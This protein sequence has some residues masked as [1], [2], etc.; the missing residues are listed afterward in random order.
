MSTASEHLLK[1]AAL[2]EF[3]TALKYK[4]SYE[5]LTQGMLGLLREFLYY[6]D[7]NGVEV[8][9]KET[10]Y[11]IVSRAQD[12]MLA[13]LGADGSLQENSRQGLDRTR[14]LVL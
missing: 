4:T 1:L 8:P 11:R 6:C 7:K 2:N 5:E 12:L 13:K 14:P 10:Y 9:D 3:E